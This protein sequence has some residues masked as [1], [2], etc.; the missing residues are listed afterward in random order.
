MDISEDPSSYIRFL[1]LSAMYNMF[2][3]S[4]GLG[5]GFG[6]FSEYF[7]HYLSSIDILIHTKELQ[8]DLTSEKK[9]APYGLLFS[10]IS[11]MGIPG[12]IA[13]LS[14]FSNIFSKYAKYKPYYIALLMSTI[15]ALPWGIPFIWALLGMLDKDI[16]ELKSRK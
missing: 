15:T 4:H 8:N 13:F 3:D 5:M 16:D 1:H 11:Q 2:I 7:R 9:I 10:V 12:L 14:I 6:S